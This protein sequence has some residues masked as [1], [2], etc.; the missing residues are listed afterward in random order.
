M[1]KKRS[2]I[3]LVLT[4]FKGCQALLFR[5]KDECGKELSLADVN[6]RVVP[7]SLFPKDLT[8]CCVESSNSGLNASYTYK[9]FCPDFRQYRFKIAE[10]RAFF[11]L[12][13]FGM[14]VSSVPQNA[15]R[16]QI[17][18]TCLKGTT[19]CTNPSLG[20]QLK[21]TYSLCDLYTKADIN[22]LK[23]SKHVCDSVLK[24]GK[25]IFE[26]ASNK[27]VNYQFVKL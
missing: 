20:S 15:G 3:I 7:V 24:D 25:E 2:N 21:N 26:E 27:Y 17:N 6:E 13:A 10:I 5:F 23:F 16:F 1:T 11:I 14:P 9:G 4:H 12:P 8:T 18:N 19:S 22:L